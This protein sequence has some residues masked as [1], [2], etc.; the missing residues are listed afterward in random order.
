[1]DVDA[2][3]DRILSI[4]REKKI[5]SSAR[6]DP[7]LSLRDRYGLDSAAMIQLVV[8]LEEAFSLE[9]D[10]VD[11]QLGNFTTIDDIARLVKAKLQRA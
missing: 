11:M 4:I 6:I 10:P 2:I 3:R 7:A 1:M 9:F 5:L 8:A